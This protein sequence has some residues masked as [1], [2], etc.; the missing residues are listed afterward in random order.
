MRVGLARVGEARRESGEAGGRDLL[1]TAGAGCG[2][3]S[4]QADAVRVWLSEGGGGD[5]EC[6][7][8]EVVALLGHE[9]VGLELCKLF[10]HELE[11]FDVAWVSGR[12]GS[13]VSHVPIWNGQ[14][15]DAA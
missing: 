6:G 1:L 8:G 4:E 9:Q 2:G 13:S 14:S 12:K 7:R 10:N 15:F 11:R 3:R 5:V